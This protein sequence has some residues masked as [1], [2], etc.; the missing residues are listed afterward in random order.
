MSIRARLTE[1]AKP[2]NQCSCCD[3]LAG[4]SA[5]DQAAIDEWLEDPNRSVAALVNVLR[6][7]GLPVKVQ[8]FRRHVQECVR[9]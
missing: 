1:L 2:K 9:S 4:R 7:E 8:Q 6:A 3:W 5:D